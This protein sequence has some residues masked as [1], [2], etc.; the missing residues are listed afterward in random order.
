[1]RRFLM[2]AALVGF[3]VMVW[4]IGTMLSSDAIGMAVGMVFGVM[5]GVPAALL[6]LATSRRSD[7]RQA[8]DAYAPVRSDR[9]LP[10][11]PYQPPVIVVTGGQA[12][13]AQPHPAQ[14]ANPPY[15]VPSNTN[16]WDTQRGERRFKVVGEREEWVK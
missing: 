4:R 8:E 3:G 12:P 1:M 11:Y 16:G 7:E 15:F 14:L 5:A 13:Q 10:A 6:V 9:Q 2:M